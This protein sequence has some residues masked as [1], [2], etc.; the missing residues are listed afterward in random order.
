M[1][2]SIKEFKLN[3]ETRVKLLLQDSVPVYWPC[4][5][6]LKKMRVRS[7]N[8]QQRFFSDLII[9]LEWL[10]YKG[11]NIEERLKKRPESV[12]LSE[13][14]LAEFSS[15]VHWKKDVLDKKHGGVRLHRSAYQQVSAF[16]SESR[17]A[18]ARNYLCFLYE[19]L[20][21]PDDRFDQIEWLVKRINLSIVQSKPSWKRRPMEPKGLTSEQERVLLNYLHP[22]S[23][24]NPWPKSLAVRFRNYLIV[25]ILYS[26]GVRRSEMLG[27]K[28][29]DVN[30]RDNR[31]SIVHRPNDPD[32]PRAEEPN[33]KT[34][35]RKLPAP[36]YLMSLI[37]EYI[38]CY[39]KSKRAK[40]HPYL[41]LSHG[42]NEGAPLSIKSVDAVFNVA[43]KNFPILMSVTPHTLRHHD[44][45]RTMK[46][47]KE[48]TKD[49]PPEERES[50][51]N[52]VCN[53]R[54]GWVDT[55]RMPGRY[56]QKFYQ[57]EASEAMK[58]LNEKLLSELPF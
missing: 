31:I 20:G 32:D 52:R 5:Y 25:I 2:F 30:Y 44:V 10:S 49:L 8:T 16:Q 55:S 23:E 40:S 21:H 13:A 6:I 15:Q 39:R 33:I 57:E 38:E 54:Y 27:I 56:G 47:L 35:E 24:Q 26:L 9:F 37:N 11:I 7:P 28:L 18:T 34:N 51:F 22:R 41:F 42:R 53:F 48:E 50:I 46:I 29:A 43:K 58:I 12:Y 19:A 3:D 4:L 14:E 17:L 1:T 36:E 45:Y